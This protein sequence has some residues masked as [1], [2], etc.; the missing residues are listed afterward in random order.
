MPVPYSKCA[1]DLLWQKPASVKGHLTFGQLF[2]LHSSWISWRVSRF[3]SPLAFFTNSTCVEHWAINLAISLSWYALA[4]K[5]S[6]LRNAF[7]AS[8]TF[9]SS[10]LWYGWQLC[11][12]GR[13]F[14]YVLL[15][16]MAT[17]TYP[18]WEN[19]KM[20]YKATQIL[21]NKYWLLSCVSPHE[22]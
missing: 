5:F 9:T 15:N 7:L 3:A 21:I 13:H 2:F 18:T 19:M 20:N 6:S 16:D 22:V 4:V 1:L 17:V 12:R 14:T 10:Y 11:D 8:S